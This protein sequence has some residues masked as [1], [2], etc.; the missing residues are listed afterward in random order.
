MDFLR[1]WLWQ[2][3]WLPIDIMG[4]ILTISWFVSRLRLQLLSPE[5][6]LQQKPVQ[7]GRKPHEVFKGQVQMTAWQRFTRVLSRTGVVIAGVILLIVGLTGASY[8]MYHNLQNTINQLEQAQEQNRPSMSLGL[9]LGA[10]QPVLNT[11]DQTYDVTLY[12]KFRNVG[13]RPAYNTVMRAGWAPSDTPSQFQTLPNLTNPNRIDAG[14][15]YG[16]EITIAIPYVVVGNQTHISSAT[17]FVFMA[18]TY[19]DNSGNAHNDP[20]W[21][22]YVSGSSLVAMGDFN[23]QQALEP[24]IA[25]IY[26]SNITKP[27]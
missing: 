7:K 19:T 5:K 27:Y 4:A 13:D 26:G 22:N 18:I 6:H 9:S 2:A 12:L 25:D 17:I 24:Y 23:E 16:P 11:Q 14:A 15:D 3:I 20:F 8:N 21:L 10:S 1:E